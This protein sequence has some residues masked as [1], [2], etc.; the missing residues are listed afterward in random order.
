M[1]EV[2]DQTTVDELAIGGLGEICLHHP[3]GTFAV[4]P[5]SRISIQAIGECRSLLSGIGLDWGSGVGGLAVAAAKIASV[6]RVVGLEIS[7]ANVQTAIRNAADNGVQDK[8]A[9]LLSDSFVPQTR[10]GRS[11]LDAISGQVGFL[12]ANPPSSEGDDGF[13]YRRRILRE[14]R[15]FLADGAVVLLSISSQ[16]GADRIDALAGDIAG[17]VHRG[18]SAS[19]DWVPF[20]LGRPDLLHCLELY[21]EEEERDGYEY[22]F[23][24][25]QNDDTLN[26]RSALKTFRRTGDNPLSMWQTHLFQYHAGSASSD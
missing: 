22:A 11:T 1:S 5:A 23:R 12:L 8:V 7:E 20:D 3:P 17:Y 21:A 18:I 19:T 26:A 9:F 25:P 14:A 15:T 6:K 16:Y 13:D 2:G 10:E 24:G 4:T